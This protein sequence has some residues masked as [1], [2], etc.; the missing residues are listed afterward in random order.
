MSARV[1]WVSF[2]T[3]VT[4]EVRRFMRIW[5]QT[6]VP[7]V[8]TASLYFLIFG[9][10]IGSRIGPMEGVSYME[11]V[12][13]GLV[14]LSVIT[15]SYM[16]TV[17]SFFGVKF[18]RSIEELLVSPTVPIV[19]LAGF[20]IGGM[21][22]GVLTGILVLAVVALVIPDF[23]IAHPGV[24]L[25]TLLLSSMMFSLLGMINGIYANTFDDISIVPTFVLTPLIY[26]G[27]VFYSTSVL[28]PLWA[29]LSGFNPI[30]Y[31]VNAFRYGILGI[32][33]IPLHIAF[34]IAVTFIVLAGG[35][36]LWMLSRSARLRL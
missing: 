15:N 24:A 12:A 35:F 26:L 36:S 22:R 32:S 29:G 2:G 1:Q 31:L 27:G 20:V 33:D 4:R 7:P 18:Q 16:N 9:G 21:T 28:S 23:R 13:P 5:V 3:I 30:L 6:L 19:I 10:L 11:F 17:S 14:M 8:I 25:V 34:F